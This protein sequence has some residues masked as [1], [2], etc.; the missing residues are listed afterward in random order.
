MSIYASA[1][2][3]ARYLPADELAGQNWWRAGS[4]GFVWEGVGRGVQSG[5][6]PQPQV[7]PLEPSRIRQPH[8]PAFNQ[9]KRL[10]VWL[11]HSRTE[12][13]M[14]N[15]P[16]RSMRRIADQEFICQTAGT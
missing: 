9:R 4:F 16:E 12:Q 5:C 7:C 2:V 11:D 13:P 6:Q 1:R 14:R 10:V 8:L 15:P 3:V